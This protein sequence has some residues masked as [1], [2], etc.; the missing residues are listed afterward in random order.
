M[1]SAESAGGRLGAVLSAPRT[2]V[3]AL[4]PRG[5]WLATTPALAKQVL[6]DVDHF[7]FPGNVSRGGDLS[8]S[9]GD[10]RSGHLVF[11]PLT[12]VQVARGVATFA[13]LWP[14][15]LAAH[16]RDTP[17]EAYDAMEL[18]RR[19]VA[20][21]TCDALLDDASTDQREA[22]GDAVLAWIDALAPVIAAAR[23][24]HRWS[25]V[26][27]VERDARL[28]LEAILEHVDGLPGTPQQ[29][30]TMLA[31]GIQVP[32][33]AGSWLLAWLGDQPTHDVDPI[34]AVWET[35]RLTPPTWITARLTTT[36]VELDGRLVPSGSVVLVSPLLLGR[37]PELVPGDPDELGDFDPSRWRDDA[38]RPGA[39][40]PFGAGPHAC[41]GRNLGMAVLV[42]LAEWAVAHRV[43]LTQEVKFD[44]SRGLAPLPCRFRLNAQ[45]GTTR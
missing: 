32:I 12:P 36:D 45:G 25:R 24:P 39:W 42:H 43:R 19:P 22:V 38:R 40:L 37:L 28:R 30:A 31:A 3:V 10:T 9:R 44:Q 34:H 18:L 15:A 7:D 13:E 4:G 33:A 6:T 35:L 8:G 1:D 21:A 20:R 11:D 26:R 17:R 14:E 23:A 5:P 41:P 27:R 29:A 16:D 2:G